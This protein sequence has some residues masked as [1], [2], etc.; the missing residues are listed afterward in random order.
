MKRRKVFRVMAVYGA[1]AFVVLQIADLVF[2]ILEFPDWTLQ[3]VLMLTL[4]GFPIAVVLAWALEATDQGIRR[5][6]PA[7]D[8]E[9]DEIITAP[10]SK[11]LPSGLLA[12]VGI[13]A[14]VLGAWW[15]GRQTAPMSEPSAVKASIAVLPFADMSPEGD[16]EY[17]SNG[18]SEELLNLLT[19]I[20]ELNV[21]ARTSS[22]SFKDQNLDIP[23]IADRLRVAH[24]LE[25]SVRKS[26]NDVRIT[27]QLIR[28]DG[29]H[30][31]SGQW[32]RTLD[33]V[34]AIQEE[35]AAEVVDT[36]KVSL[37]GEL[38][39]LEVVDPEAHALYLQAR[40]V[41]GRREGEP[42]LRSTE[43]LQRA[44]DI[45]PEFAA[46]WVALAGSYMAEAASLGWRPFDEGFRLARDAVDRALAID[47]EYAPAHRALA[48][49]AINV[50][51]DLAAAAQH[52]ERALELDR[53]N[54]L[55]TAGWLL[56]LV[57]RPDEALPLLEYQAA[58][59]PV[60]PYVHRQ[61]GVAYLSTGRTDEA[62]AS[63]RTA[64]DLNPALKWT[65]YPIGWA[66]LERGKLKEA[67]LE[68]QQESH[69][70]I[71]TM[72][73]SMAYHAL[74]R[75]AES[76]TALAQLIEMDRGKNQ[77]PVQIAYALAYRGE[78][79]RA[80]EWLRKAVE[81]NDPGLWTDAYRA[82]PLANLHDDPRWLPFLESI[83]RSPEQ[84]AAIDFQAPFLN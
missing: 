83:G 4:L 51:H 37:L 43:L 22:F 61:L 12:L 39:K 20:P 52:L 73:L 27:A 38:P 11:R 6:T 15:V 47:P 13:V 64:L 66:L 68:M 8:A 34:F 67:L 79:D 28:A 58:R 81:Y 17:F 21:T 62:I 10:A 77:W 29:F 41:T 78:A 1:T 19:K 26:G 44:L 55:G 33:D 72:G 31:W 53:Q 50:D 7:T 2:P 49:L 18:I 76:D 57:N 65:H 46:A 75:A 84:L 56:R 16:Q 24:V 82:L 40:S 80:F 45:D 35:I 69:P 60:N 48:G 30:V 3:L 70:E 23:V 59:D 9:L 25:G 36:L 14:L 54:S 42:Y 74:G 5:T 63:L 32:D 71:R